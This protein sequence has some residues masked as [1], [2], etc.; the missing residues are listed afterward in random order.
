MSVGPSRCLG[1]RDQGHA[2]LVHFIENASHLVV[3]TRT[4]ESNQFLVCVQTVSNLPRCVGPERFRNVQRA[5]CILLVA[6]YFG[7]ADSRR[8]GHKPQHGKRALAR[9][10]SHWEKTWLLTLISK[11]NLSSSLTFD[12]EKNRQFFRAIDG[13]GIHKLAA[14]SSQR[15]NERIWS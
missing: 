15:S 6:R 4:T 12:I 14:T 7:A 2:L 1:R 3:I 5:T 11:K 8:N 10:R 9:T 13:M